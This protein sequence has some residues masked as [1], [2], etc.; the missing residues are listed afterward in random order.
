MP[1][2]FKNLQFA[3]RLVSYLNLCLLVIIIAALAT[4]PASAEGLLSRGAKRWLLSG[5]LAVAMF[6]LVIKLSHAAGVVTTI[7]RSTNESAGDRALQLPDNFYGWEAYAITGGSTGNLSPD[8]AVRMKVGKESAFGEVPPVTVQ[9]ARAQNVL[10]HVQPFPWNQLL[11][12]GQ[13]VAAENSRRL[14]SGTIVSL[15]A[16]THE[17]TYSWR[18]TA[19]WK[20]LKISSRIGTVLWLSLAFAACVVPRLSKKLCFAP[21]DRV[22]SLTASGVSAP[23]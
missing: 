4:I 8:A 10:I 18:P 15:T 3:Y 2:V 5:T 12:D 23:Q 1:S 21:W 19:M 7:V 16:G 14:S 13:P 17:I 6:G 11:I 20:W 9:L 22:D